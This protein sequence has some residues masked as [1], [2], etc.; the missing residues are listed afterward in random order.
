MPTLA[1]EIAAPRVV[2][3]LEGLSTGLGLLEGIRLKK[4]RNEL[5]SLFSSLSLSPLIFSA[6]LLHLLD[7]EI[8]F[9]SEG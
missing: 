3:V 1:L 9:F 7:F 8:T 5:F 6:V 2:L 4:L